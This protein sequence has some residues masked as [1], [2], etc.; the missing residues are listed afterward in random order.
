MA[1]IREKAQLMSASEINRT[2]VRLAHEILEKTAD[3]DR[4][5]FIGILRKGAPLAE[6]LASKIESLEQRKIPVGV[7]DTVPYRD[8]LSEADRPSADY[9]EIPFAITGKD[10]VHRRYH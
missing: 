4:L 1:R 5:A 9:T 2:V 6:R 3:L 10:V 7:V 8:D